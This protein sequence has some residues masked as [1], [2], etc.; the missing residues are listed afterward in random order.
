MPTMKNRDNDNNKNVSENYETGVQ[1]L[2]ERVPVNYSG[3]VT[4][5]S[6]EKTF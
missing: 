5:Q 4:Y 6:L 2:K 1:V 3:K